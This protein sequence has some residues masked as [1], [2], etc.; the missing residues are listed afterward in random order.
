MRKLTEEEKQKKR[1]YKHTPEARAKISE[2]LK[3]RKRKKE[4]Y[5]KTIATRIKR[6]NYKHT[7]KAKERMSKTRLGVPKS[8]E[9][10]QNLRNY[11]K[12]NPKKVNRTFNELYE[13]IRKC[14]ES[15]QWRCDVFR[16]DNY[17][18][19]ICGDN[20]GGNLEADHKKAFIVILKE[21]N[22]QSLEEALACAELWDI[23]NGRTLCK[24][25]HRT[26]ENY[27]TKAKRR[28]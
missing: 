5:N 2:A 6:D 1:E 20:T 10:R 16:R 11:F 27:G 28:S 26:T 22:I 23:D 25:C 21:Y 14:F 3:L 17:T 18:C 7:D 15:R 24:P 8:I 12:K 13:L 9:F 19:Q 4:T